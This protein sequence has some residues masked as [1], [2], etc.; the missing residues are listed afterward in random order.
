M[1]IN[2]SPDC[3]KWHNPAVFIAWTDRNISLTQKQ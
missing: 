2:T 3:P 1:A